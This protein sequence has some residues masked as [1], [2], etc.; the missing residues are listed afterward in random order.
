MDIAAGKPSS[1]TNSDFSEDFASSAPDP[2]GVWMK[3]RRKSLR[4]SLRA[5]AGEVGVSPTAFHNWEMGKTRPRRSKLAAISEVLVVSQRELLTR[6]H[7]G[8]EGDASQAAID[9]PTLNMSAQLSDVIDACKEK[10]AAA[11]GT[12]S[13]NVKIVIEI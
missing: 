10:V 9:A 5:A 8:T 12:S 13:A 6:V 7:E 4:L 1:N 2:F 11:A 3:A